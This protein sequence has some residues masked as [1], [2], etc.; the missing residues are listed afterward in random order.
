M[1]EN[2]T[3]E[4]EITPEEEQERQ[5]ARRLLQNWLDYYQGKWPGHSVGSYNYG[6]AN[7]SKLPPEEQ[8]LWN[9]KRR[10]VQPSWG[11]RVLGAH[12]KP[13]TEQQRRE[14]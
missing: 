12:A 8:E 11:A 13:K 5:K 10:A 4:P 3:P 14:E 1:P 7:V 2:T 9:A 6:W